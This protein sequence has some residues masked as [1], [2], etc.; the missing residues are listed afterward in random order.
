[1][2]SKKPERVS[3][4]ITLHSTMSREWEEFNQYFQLFQSHFRFLF[5][6]LFYSLRNILFAKPN[7]FNSPKSYVTHFHKGTQIM[8]QHI[9]FYVLSPFPMMQL[10][11]PAMAGTQ[12]QTNEVDCCFSYRYRYEH[13]KAEGPPHNIV[14]AR[15]KTNLEKWESFL[16]SLCQMCWV[17]YGP[18]TLVR[19]RTE[20]EKEETNSI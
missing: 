13:R 14:S 2:S 18:R 1:M 16:A 17:R 20:S 10:Q 3:K 19:R 8:P 4:C 15:E 7:N 6:F 12:Q 5:W 11:R 9:S